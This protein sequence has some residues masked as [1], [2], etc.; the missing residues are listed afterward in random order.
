MKKLLAMFALV[1]VL[2]LFMGCTETPSEPE[3][4]PEN[5]ETNNT[6]EPVEEPTTESNVFKGF[7]DWEPGMWVEWKSNDLITRMAIV[8]KSEGI[9]KF[10]TESEMQGMNSISQIWY[11]ENTMEMK[12][13]ITK[14]DEMVICFEGQEGDEPI[15]PNEDEAYEGKIPELG[16]GTYTT[17]TGKT[18]SVAKFGTPEGEYWVSDEVL[19]GVVKVKFGDEEQMILNDFGTTGAVNKITSEDIANCQDLGSM[20]P[21]Q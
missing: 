8:E 11:D 13:Y 20:F 10:Q 14:T 3:V 6:T 17:P 16:Y 12:K 9:L 21:T 19:F 4:T 15:D 5:G 2:L 1:A 7:V 18:V